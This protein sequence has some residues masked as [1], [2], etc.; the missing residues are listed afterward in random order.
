MEVDDVVVNTILFM[1]DNVVSIIQIRLHLQIS[2][3]QSLSRAD[4]NIDLIT[5]LSLN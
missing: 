3:H 5:F 4:F 2:I 1:I